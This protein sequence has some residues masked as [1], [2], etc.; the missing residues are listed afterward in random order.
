MDTWGVRPCGKY[1]RDM[2]WLVLVGGHIMAIRKN[3]HWGIR[4]GGE[5]WDMGDTVRGVGR[6]RDNFGRYWDICDV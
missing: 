4:P 5:I 3:R 2:R 1:G 6:F